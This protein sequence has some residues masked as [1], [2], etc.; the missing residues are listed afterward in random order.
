[1]LIYSPPLTPVTSAEYPDRAFAVREA[2]RQDAVANAAKTEEPV[3]VLAM[4][5]IVGDHTGRIR[6]GVLRQSKRYAVALP[7]LPILPGITLERGIR[8]AKEVSRRPGRSNINIWRS[9]L[10]D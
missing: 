8:H 6:E 10:L 7:I 9:V 3:F 1:L 4:R 2:H 5:H